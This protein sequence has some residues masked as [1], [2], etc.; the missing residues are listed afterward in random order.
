MVASFIPL[1]IVIVIMWGAFVRDIDDSWFNVETGV[2]SWHLIQTVAG[3]VWRHTFYVSKVDCLALIVF[4]VLIVHIGL[5]Y[6]KF[7]R[8]RGYICSRRWH[9]L[10]GREKIRQ[11]WK[12]SDM[13]LKMF[14]NALI[15]SRS[16]WRNLFVVLACGADAFDRRSIGSWFCG[17]LSYIFRGVDNF[18]GGFSRSL[19]ALSVI[20]VAG[21][22]LLETSTAAEVTRRRWYRH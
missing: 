21:R 6:I 10:L 19:Q 2:T 18:W 8:W 1:L 17:V 7:L 13:A 15:V 16:V 4:E 3:Y 11:A 9:V 12:D 20:E 5:M 22:H 14:S